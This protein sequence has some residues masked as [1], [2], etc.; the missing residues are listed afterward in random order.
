MTQFLVGD[1]VTVSGGY[2]GEASA[3]LADGVGY[4]GR[5]VAIESQA[6]VVELDSNLELGSGEWQDFG[7]GSASSIRT[8]RAV[9][10][11]WLVL[12]QG[13]VGGTWSSP[14]SR[15]HVAVCDEVPVLERVPPGGGIGVWVESHATMTKL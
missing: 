4:A 6:A 2:D 1:R 9:R 7:Q 10:G 12:L 14:T 8:V 5:L 3:W 15:L 11:R 13:W